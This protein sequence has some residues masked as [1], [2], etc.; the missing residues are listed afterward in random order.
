MLVGKAGQ[1]GVGREP[2]MEFKCGGVAFTVT[3]GVEGPLSG[4]AFKLNTMA[5][6]LAAGFSPQEGVQEMYV[7]E[8]ATRRKKSA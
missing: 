2:V 8:G 4:G 5:K 1:A 3:G 7:K 6:S